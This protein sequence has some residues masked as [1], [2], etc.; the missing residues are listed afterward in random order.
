MTVKIW[1]YCRPIVQ[2]FYQPVKA[3]GETALGHLRQLLR[4]N[5]IVVI[6]GSD[7]E[8][9]HLNSAIGKTQLFHSQAWLDHLQCNGLSFYHHNEHHNMRTDINIERIPNVDI[10]VFDEIHHFFPKLQ[11]SVRPEDV[12]RFWEKVGEL[13]E[14]GKTVIFVTA[15]HPQNE[16]YKHDLCRELEYGD[17]SMGEL[18]AKHKDSL[19]LKAIASFFMAPVLEFLSITQA[20]YMKRVRE[21]RHF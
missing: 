3:T 11:S 8:R 13:I 10:Y 21:Q 4:S 7:K 9:F 12:M 17:G 2:H 20:E 18:F 16:L 15:L 19:G 6:S 14:I 1:P 5:Q